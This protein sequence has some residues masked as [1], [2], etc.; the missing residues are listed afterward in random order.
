MYHV[1]FLTVICVCLFLTACGGGKSDAKK[2]VLSSLKDPDSAKFG[3][4]TQIDDKYACFGVNARNSM[5]GYTGEQQA[6]LFNNGKEWSVLD[7]KEMGH[8]AC[9][10][11]LKKVSADTSA[12]EE[13]AKRLHEAMKLRFDVTKPEVVIDT[14]TG[15]MWAKNSK[16]A[17]RTMKREE[18]IT[19][20][21][22]LNY[23]GKNGWRLP[24]KEEW[25]EFTNFDSVNSEWLDSVSK[26]GFMN[27]EPGSFYWSSSSNPGSTNSVWIMRGGSVTD[28]HNES[29]N[30]WPVRAGK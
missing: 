13:R 9:I 11:V 3:K 5:G 30:V 27:I 1:K 26:F 8:E 29:Y 2:A 18:A 16:I 25:Q 15:L 24:S 7:I 19:W 20:A 10:E 22:N 21:Q 28:V 4:F 14:K 12:K 17:G 23:A 6:V